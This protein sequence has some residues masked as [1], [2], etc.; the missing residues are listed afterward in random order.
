MAEA[1][2]SVLAEVLRPKLV[3]YGGLLMALV[4]AWDAI[5]NQFSLPKMG[6][7]LGM[8]GSLLPWWGWLLILQ[9]LFVYGLFEYVRQASF[10]DT[11]PA[12]DDSELRERLSAAEAAIKALAQSTDPSIAEQKVNALW[13]RDQLIRGRAELESEWQNVCS[14]YARLKASFIGYPQQ[15]ALHEQRRAKAVNIPLVHLDEAVRAWHMAANRLGAVYG[16]LGFQVPELFNDNGYKDSLLKAAPE[17]PEG[18]EEGLRHRFRRDF[19]FNVNLGR[20]YK[21][22]LLELN[23][24]MGKAETTLN[25]KE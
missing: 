24:E 14:K 15:A 5:S 9:A 2:K 7:L 17:E 8:S 16:D 21:M 13:R 1:K 4:A 10:P 25:R 22:M 12:H 3:R 6:R 11:P 18:L 20:T 19:Y 23:L